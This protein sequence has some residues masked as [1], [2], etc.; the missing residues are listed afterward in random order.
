MSKRTWIIIGVVAVALIALLTLGKGKNSNAISVE[1][2]EVSVRTIV[3]TVSASGKIQPEVEVK[4]SP[5]V[6]GEIIALPIEEGQTVEAGDLLVSINPDLYRAAVNR[7][8]AAVNSAR[9]GKSQAEAQFVEAEK[10]YNRSKS[11]FEQN[12]ISQAEWD[13]AQRAFRVAELG[14]E[15]AEFQLQSAEATYKEAQDNLKRTTIVAP[16]SGTIS[17]LNIELG[18]RVVGTAQMAGTEL[19]RIAN[20]NDMEVLVEVNENDIVKVG[21]NDTATIEVDAYLGK[22]FTGVVTEIANSAKID[23][24]TADQVTNFEVKVRILRES[25]VDESETQPFRPGMTASVDIRTNRKAGII[26]VPI[27]AVTVRDD[28][29][30]MSAAEKIKAKVDDS[31]DDPYEVVFVPDGRKSRLVVVT[32]GIQDETHIEILTGL[33]EGQTI[34]TGPYEAV[35]KSLNPD[36]LI[37][38][39]DESNEEEE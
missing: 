27:E 20:L 37:E 9:A 11:L 29:V 12:V 34:I 15:S 14:V 39:D 19:M 32:T 3:E 24:M 33:E 18:E 10:S 38:Y 21:L 36:D 31:K 13:A 35:S 7:S 17:A 2:G 28:T 1:T 16:V 23:G 26:T 4:I 22:K 30:S 6:S 25:Y 8:R 5:E